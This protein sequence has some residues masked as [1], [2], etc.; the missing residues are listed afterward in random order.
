[1]KKIIAIVAAT[2]VVAVI[3][4]VV[5]IGSNIDGIVKSG[6]ETYG[7]RFTGTAVRLGSVSSSLMGGEVSINEFFLGNPKGFKAPYAFKVNKVKVTVDT[8]S[9][10]SDVVHIKEIIIEA[11][12]IIYEMGGGSSNLQAIQNNV[13]KAAGGGGSSKSSEGAGKK[14][15]IDNLYVRNAKAALSASILGSK[16]IP[17]PLPDLHLKDIG[18]EKKGASMSDATK[19]VLD[20]ITK[21]A[22]SAAG[23]IDIKGIAAGAGKALEDAKKGAEGALDGATKGLKGLFGK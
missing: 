21:S 8:S 17:L 7:P 13:A 11:P 22:T 16:T 4:V 9:L 2:L 20:E 10:T 5:Y 12:D 6:V 19:Q 15:V 14:V 18:K 3:G 23:K 1:M